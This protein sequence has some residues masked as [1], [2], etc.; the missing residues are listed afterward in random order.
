MRMNLHQSD[1]VKRRYLGRYY[2]KQNQFTNVG[3]FYFHWIRD[4]SYKNLPA[5]KCKNSVIYG[6]L[7]FNYKEKN[8][9]K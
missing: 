7:A 1:N 6:Y 9:M 5:K 4:L 8:F 2:C 3:R